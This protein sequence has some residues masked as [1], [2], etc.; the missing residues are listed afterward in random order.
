MENQ[1][2][3]EAKMLWVDPNEGWKYG[4]PKV[5]DPKIYSDVNDFLKAEGFPGEPLYV[6]FWNY[7]EKSK[8][9]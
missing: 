8:S 7:T 3:K 4:F 5:W 6:R 1:T 9:G 2:T